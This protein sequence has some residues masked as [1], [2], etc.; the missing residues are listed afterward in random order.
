[1]NRACST[2]EM[3]IS[4][5]GRSAEART[6]R[7]RH[8]SR[9]PRLRMYP[10]YASIL[11]PRRV[12]NRVVRPARMRPEHATRQRPDRRPHDEHDASP[13][14]GHRTAEASTWHR[15]LAGVRMV[16]G[17]DPGLGLRRTPPQPGLGDRPGRNHRWATPGDRVDHAV[18]RSAVP[19]QWA[20]F[21]DGVPE[22]DREGDLVGAY[23]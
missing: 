4:C 6:A 3:D 1:M 8:P 9:R 10:G 19:E 14:R 22:A 20:R 7:R 17:L 15:A 21:R 23:S 5:T 2:L 13:P 12:P 11:R 16:L 18:G